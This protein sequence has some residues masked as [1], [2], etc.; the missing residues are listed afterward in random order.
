M[1]SILV[2]KVFFQ[3]MNGQRG[4]YTAAAMFRDIKASYQNK[5]CSVMIKTQM[6]S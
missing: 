3:R 1:L 6:A 5:Q 2:I 4:W